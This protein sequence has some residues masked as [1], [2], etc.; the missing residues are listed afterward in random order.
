MTIRIPPANTQ[1]PGAVSSLDAD[2]SELTAHQDTK[3]HTHAPRGGD[4]WS[5]LPATLALREDAR[6]SAD[7]SRSDQGAVLYFGPKVAVAGNTAAV[8]VRPAKPEEVGAL[9]TAL[10]HGGTIGDLREGNLTRADQIVLNWLHD[11]VKFEVRSGKESYFNEKTRT[12]VLGADASAAERARAVVFEARRMSH[13]AHLQGIK[14]RLGQRDY[15]NVNYR[16]NGHADP[17][18]KTRYEA[19]TREAFVEEKIR[20]VARAASEAIEFNRR[21]RAA[22]RTATPAPLEDVY[23]AAYQSAY[24]TRYGN[25]LAESGSHNFADNEARDAGA[26]AGRAAVEAAIKNGKLTAPD[27]RETYPQV[28]SRQWDAKEAV[29]AKE[30]AELAKAQA[31]AKIESER[32]AKIAAGAKALAELVNA[33]DPK[34]PE[35]AQVI[36][37]VRAFAA[38]HPGAH[39]TLFTA[40]AYKGLERLL[41]PFGFRTAE[42]VGNHKMEQAR[43]HYALANFERLSPKER[44]LVLKHPELG[45]RFGISHMITYAEMQ[46]REQ[47]FVNMRLPDGSN[48]QGTRAAYREASQQSVINHA[49]G[50]LAQIR[51]A[52]PV[53]LVG[54]IV[55][56]EKG[57]AIGQMFD[58]FMPLAQMRQQ[59]VDMQH[60][61]NSSRPDPRPTAV[62]SRPPPA[63]PPGSETQPNRTG[64]PPAPPPNGGP[65]GG[66]GGQP[67]GNTTI[68]GPPFGPPRTPANVAPPAGNNAPAQNNPVPRG[69]Q[70]GQDMNTG[71]NDPDR[72]ARRNQ[73]ADRIAAQER[74]AR[75]D[76]ENA[77]RVAA[78]NQHAAQVANT[79]PARGSRIT[80]EQ[81][82]NGLEQQGWPTVASMNSRRHVEAW[83]DAGNTGNPPVVFR[84]GNQIRIDFQRLNAQDQQRFQALATRVPQV[85]GD[86]NVDARAGTWPE[87]PRGNVG[88]GNA[89]G[90]TQPG[91]PRR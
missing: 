49:L 51:K 62:E 57:A 59:R 28:F 70:T 9:H 60:T 26:A 54:R 45:G 19:K 52:G 50:Q 25:V 43:L 82:L 16:T 72:V 77:R 27:T 20:N 31:A 69:Q 12:M 29:K 36:E 88:G 40:D 75:H 30:A 66:S 35:A 34:S 68:P 6:T 80:P 83:H 14:D 48:F 24:A 2:A 71:A 74:S 37:L 23:T 46:A 33:V 86:R 7:T 87:P 22:G 32:N 3:P 64:G 67:A 81:A 42:E 1:V 73:Q 41:G 78:A 8:V 76:A 39:T 65:N 85:A 15:D 63:R 13:D 38:Q 55:G 58:S 21:E 84:D 10:A 5:G 4:P 17:A 44:D 18:L 79:M 90:T 89:T 53:S 11:G 61:V 56:G 47:Q 91:T